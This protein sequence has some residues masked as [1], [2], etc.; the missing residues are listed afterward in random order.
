MPL[1]ADKMPERIQRKRTKGWRMPPGTVYV[2][3][4]T[5]F[6]NPFTIGMFKD[7]DAADAV[8]S[9]RRWVNR[10]LSYRSTENA[11]GKPPVKSRI[12]ADLRGKNL[13]CWCPVIRGGAYMPCHTDVL[14]SLANDIPLEDVIHE[15]TRR[16]K[17]EAL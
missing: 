12:R 2:G 13:C 6:G 16:A 7:Y 4:P 9:F 14:I 5:K 3:R 1:S 10:D 15:N 17:G 8:C 11:F